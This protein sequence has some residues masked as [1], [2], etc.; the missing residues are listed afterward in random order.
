MR[1]GGLRVELGT[2]AMF[3]FPKFWRVKFEVLCCIYKSRL[4]GLNTEEIGISISRIFGLFEQN[5]EPLVW[6]FWPATFFPE[7]RCLE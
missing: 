2:V 4:V 3:G 6:L 5:L 1:G 7:I